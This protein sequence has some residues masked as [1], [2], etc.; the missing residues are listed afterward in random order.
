MNGELLADQPLGEKLI[1]KGF[2][3][4]FFTILIA[5]T[6]YF[7][8]V[9][10]SNSV[11]VADVGII[12]SIMGFIGILSAYHDLG[13]TEALQY[14]LPKYRIQKKYNAF[15]TS[16]Y[17]T[18]VIQTITGLIIAFILFFG[19]NY[20]GVYYFHSPESVHIIKIFCL[21]FLGMN[22]YNI[23]YSI[24]I[25][26]QDVIQYKIIEGIRGYTTLIFTILFFFLGSLNITNFTRAWILGLGISLIISGIIFR[27]KYGYTLQKGKI[28]LEKSLI[29]KQIQYAFRIFIGINVIYLLSQIDQQF[30][31]YFLGAEKAGYYANYLSLILSFSIFTA[32]LLGYLFPLTTELLEKKEYEKIRK[33][34]NILYKLFSLFAI[35]ISGLFIAFG[36]EIATILFGKKF[37]YS[38]KLL[39]YSAG[40][41]IFYVLFNINLSFL[42]GMGK[43]KQRAKIIFITL[44]TNIIFNLIFIYLRG[45]I[46]VISATMISRIMLFIMSYK[47][48]DKRKEISFNR[49]Y[50][51]KNLVV[52]IILSTIIIIYKNNIFVLEDMYRYKNLMYFVLTGIGYYIIIGSVNYKNIQYVLKEIKQLKKE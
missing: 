17:F 25:S 9:I 47:L 12:Y 43:V 2:W 29:K 31:I 33:L 45:V 40:F 36:P 46:G 41:L 44:I 26:F 18:M 10:V 39:T 52:I 32:P 34:K 3:L 4:Y 13:L 48:I 6:G 5:P 19:A 23:L 20:L 38:G 35:S 11:S 16:I 21:Y 1:K 51:I 24:Y 8:R 14:H 42:A 15:K 22:F 27:K 50:L 37:L 30:I 28:Q 49:G 7:I